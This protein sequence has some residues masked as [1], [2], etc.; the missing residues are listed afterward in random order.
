MKAANKN[1]TL[2]KK[3][4]QIQ[5]D[6]MGIRV[7]NHKYF[8][9]SAR[10]QL[11]VRK[12]RF[13]N[14]LYHNQQDLGSHE[15]SLAFEF[16]NQSFTGTKLSSHFINYKKRQAFNSFNFRDTRNDQQHISSFTIAQELTQDLGNH[17]KFNILAGAA[18]CNDSLSGRSFITPAANIGISYDSDEFKSSINYSY[19]PDS[20]NVLSPFEG[21]QINKSIAL[22]TRVKL[23][24]RLDLNLDCQHIQSRQIL[25]SQQRDKSI[26]LAKASLSY[27]IKSKLRANV[28]YRLVDQGLNSLDSYQGTKTSF[29][30]SYAAF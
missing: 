2:Q 18:H 9:L 29:S 19:G 26:V 10:N 22:N 13:L 7:Q 3:H 15:S 11:I 30:L 4:I 23:N 6:H 14:K 12:D 8:Q 16:V 21:A 27:K 1:A 17:L 20:I 25:D 5:A 28:H 24:K